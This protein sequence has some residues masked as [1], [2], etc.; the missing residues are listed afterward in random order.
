MIVGKGASVSVYQ[1]AT[2][3]DRFSKVAKTHTFELPQS[4]LCGADDRLVGIIL[5]WDGQVAFATVH[6]VVG[7]FP[8]DPA[9][10]DAAHVRSITVTPRSTCTAGNASREEVSNSIGAD[11]HRRASTPSPA[12]R[13]TSTSGTAAA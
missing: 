11:E 5:T 3:G 8:D 2:A 1:D 9:K 13:S 12:P 6:G 10:M 7:V 4:A